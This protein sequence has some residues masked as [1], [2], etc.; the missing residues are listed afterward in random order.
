[1]EINR[2][3][4]LVTR[5]ELFIQATPADVWK[6]HTDI[7]AWSQWQPD[8]TLSRLDAPLIVGSMFQWKSG[9]LTITATV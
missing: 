1:M 8:I 5:K 2:Q 4:P 6:I 9:G 7:N 3:A